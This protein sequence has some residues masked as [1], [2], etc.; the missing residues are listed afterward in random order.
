MLSVCRDVL[1]EP[2]VAL[3][4]LNCRLSYSFRWPHN[5][6]IVLA[7]SSSGGIARSPYPERRN[8]EWIAL[9][10]FRGRYSEDPASE[11]ALIRWL[12]EYLFVTDERWIAGINS[13]LGF[14]FEESC[15]EKEGQLVIIMFQPGVSTGLK[16]ALPCLLFQ[17]RSRLWLFLLSKTA[18][19]FL[20]GVLI[21]IGALKFVPS[22]FSSIGFARVYSADIDS[23]PE[24]SKYSV[25]C[26]FIES[27]G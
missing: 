20:S 19:V 11:I 8:R 15:S 1:F 6:S 7:S 3:L 2:P 22:L 26:I 17:H 14:I 21:I 18:S 9:E 12:H 27:T 10:I 13:M 4:S 25:K 16:E 5:L 23:V 24:V